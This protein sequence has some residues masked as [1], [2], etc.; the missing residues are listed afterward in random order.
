ML[1]ELYQCVGPGFSLHL[2]L[3][4][5]IAMFQEKSEK[6]RLSREESYRVLKEKRTTEILSQFQKTK[7]LWEKKAAEDGKQIQQA[8]EQ[9]GIQ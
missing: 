6:A 3:P 4:I 9:Q 2:S 1:I 5:A 7:L 8:W